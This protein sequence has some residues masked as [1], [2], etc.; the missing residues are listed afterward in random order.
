M[1]ARRLAAA[2]LT[3]LACHA[4]HPA[5]APDLAARWLAA[6][7]PVP[8]NGR[9]KNAGMVVREFKA[10][11]LIPF[12]P[13]RVDYTDY[14][15]VLKPLQVLG[16]DLVIVE[17][18]YM[19]RYVGCCVSEGA[20]MVLRLRGDAARLEA[21]AQANKCSVEKFKD[22]AAYRE[23]NPNVGFPLPAGAYAALSCRAR[24][25]AQ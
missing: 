16:H 24:D 11:G 15:P 5:E 23:N 13:E 6:M 4:A 12:K 3:A 25:E 7:R 9:Q 21:F 1:H 18:E 10:A 17:E 2:L 22:A 20:G 8:D 19:G 14:Y